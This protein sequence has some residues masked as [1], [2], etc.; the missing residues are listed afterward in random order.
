M[1]ATSKNTIR[2]IA[3]TKSRFLSILL[4]CMLGV[5]FFSGVRATQNIMKTSADDYFDAHNLFDLRVMCTFGLTENDEAALAA[6]DGIDGAYAAKYTDLALHKEDEEYLT[7]VF[8]Y[9]E[10]NN[11]AVNTIN[12]FEG[13]MPEAEDECIISANSLRRSIP[14]GS[15]ISLVDL[16]EAEE[17]PLARREYTVVGLYKTPMYISITQRGSTTIGDG[18]LDAFMIV[19]E[20][21]FTAGVFTEIYVK[22][23]KLQSL[24]SYS[25]EYKSL[26]DELYD[27][28]EAIADERCAARYDEVFGEAL[29]D[30]EQ[31]EKDLEKAKLDGEKELSEAKQKLDDSQSALDE[32]RKQAEAALNPALPAAVLEQMKAQMNAQ[33]EAAQKQIDEGREEYEKALRE[34]NEKIAD[35]EKE[36]ADGKREIA[37]AGYPEW[38]IFD[39]EDNIGYAE[40]ESNSERIGKIANIFPVFFLLVAGLVCLT[41]MSRMVEEQRTQIGTLKA[42]GY[43]KGAIMRHYMVYAVSGAVVGGTAG[44]F[45]GCVLFPSVIVYAYSMMYDITKIH[46]L[47]EPLNIVSAILSM[48]AAIALTVFFSCSKALK[49]TPA[50]LMRPKAPKAGKRVLI[51]RIPFIWN[52]LNFFAKVSGRNIFR[53]KRRMFMTVVGIAGC[54]A[55]SLTGLGL[56]NSISDIIDIQYRDIYRY[57]GYIAYDNEEDADGSTVEKSLLEYNGDTALTR[58]VIKQYELSFGENTTRAYVTAIEKPEVFESFVS[59]R[60]RKSKQPLSL[61]DGALITEKA[62]KL[63][64]ASVGDEITLSINE[65]EKKSFR[66]AGITEQYSSHYLYLT[67]RDYEEIFG[68]PP[69]YNM[70]YFQNG[71]AEDEAAENAFSEFMLKNDSVLAVMMNGS[72]LNAMSD[73]LEIMDL[74]VVVLIVSAAALAFVVLYNLTN[75]N[76]TERIREIATL[77][78]L[79]F[80]DMEVANYIFRENIILSL[81]GAAVGLLLGR[82]LCMFVITTAEIDEVMFGRSIHAMSYIL[83][84]VITVAF[85]LIVNAIMTKVLKKISMVESLKSVE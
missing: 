80:Y 28:I 17:F 82:A 36:I 18:A 15:K 6:I 13:R 45:G 85:S 29:S 52:K 34:Y 20:S 83:A 40:Y 78:V 59:L 84:F 53:Y 47:F 61:S 62:A 25:D 63:L 1:K 27:K 5:G 21:E 55:L 35:A 7:R 9:T 30:I 24:P 26:R 79:G 54:T 73:M 72:S 58:A 48:T 64:G 10:E 76:I 60:E 4:I 56:K 66:I 32:Q 68:N 69:E 81:M 12:L 42:L 57:S 51:E 14:V 8:S 43:S 75:V 44:A 49:E 38:Y 23:E 39:R 50:S 67:S 70:V 74:V 37:D 16:S 22:S 19:P 2:E 46:F 33:F 41:T 65:S 71:I 77:K 11:A 3:R 31:G